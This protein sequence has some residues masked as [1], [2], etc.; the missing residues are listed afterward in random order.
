MEP[1]R[2][3]M[4]G[5]DNGPRAL[6]LHGLTGSPTEL[7]PLACALAR[8]GWRAELPLWPGH[9]GAPE[10]LRRIGAA[11]LL[12]FGGDL[13]LS[14]QPVALVGLSMGALAALALASDRPELR[15]LV[16]LAPAIRLR[17]GSR[18]F[19]AL[20]GLPRL[21]VW[22]RRLVPKG[23]SGMGEPE[24]RGPTATSPLARAALDAPPPPIDWPRA[25]R[26]PLGWA[27]ELRT[28]RRQA[29]RA[30]RAITTP[31]LVVQGL[32]DKTAH[33][34][35]AIA[36]ARWLGG[37][38]T[39]D[40]VPGASHQLGLGPQRG[41]VAERVAAFLREHASGDHENRLLDR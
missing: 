18:V 37:R 29:R 1:D 34:A 38:C 36:A 13:L 9:G 40:F 20:A 30:A 39:L 41:V 6:V 28:M 10:D 5:P 22:T 32:A 31:T 12:R 8:D 24:H 27:H 16:L 15:A 17:G 3:L 25:D 23:G 4:I 7:W 21:P 35:S 33:P 2:A 11:D 14:R 19:Q 26:V